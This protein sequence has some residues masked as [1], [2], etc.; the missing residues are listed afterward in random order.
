MVI[1]GTTFDPVAHGFGAAE[2]KI[3]AALAREYVAVGAVVA[4]CRDVPRAQALA[5][6]YTLAT[7]S[8]LDAREV[9]A[10]AGVRAR[11][12]TGEGMPATGVAAYRMP[13]AHGAPDVGASVLG[14]TQR[15]RSQ[16]SQFSAAGVAHRQAITGATTYRV[17]GQTGASSSPAGEGAV[18]EASRP[19]RQTMSIPVG[20]AMPIPV[21]G[22]MPIGGA[23]PTARDGSGRPLRQTIS[24]PAVGA[25]TTA[26]SAPTP[27][28]PL[29]PV[30]EKAFRD[31]LTAKLAAVD[32]GADH[33]A[34]LEVNRA[35][36][37]QEIKTA[38]FN[39][40]KLYHPDRLAVLQLPELR[41][42][43]ER[44]FAA[45]SSAYATLDDDVKRK[46]YLD[47]LGQGG[48]SA[49]RR[50]EDEEGARAARILAAEGSYHQGE[51]ALRRNQVPQAVDHFKRAL[52]LN[53]EEADHHAMYAWCV[54]L[55]ATDKARVAGEVRKMLL[56]AVEL[57]ENC[58]QAHY[59]LGHVAL[60]L[61]QHDRALAKFNEV[62]EKNRNHVDAQREARL[63][64]RRLERGDVG[65][66]K[67]GP[68]A[69]GRSR[70][71][72]AG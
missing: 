64:Q 15:M 41:S 61:G 46:G 1:G 31:Q 44:I 24:M 60:Q 21:G 7:T 9:G 5:V 66:G 13:E 10:G 26:A 43:A 49:V 11:S 4:A 59:Y 23:L 12:M 16:T 53:G 68:G 48:H 38:Y 36:T 55:T 72:S 70:G 63:L 19:R 14:A 39:L 56:K 28:G 17:P 69:T 27:M 58:V 25:R 67:G 35:G 47:I 29:D 6:I 54:W 20:G 18:P 34:L 22:A 52:D 57:S 42:N 8:A 2:M 37:R 65:S 51:M 3:V 40:A 30:Q 33:F 45:L 32:A 50:K 62:L 71:S